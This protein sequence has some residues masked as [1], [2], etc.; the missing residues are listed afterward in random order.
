MNV[1]ELMRQAQRMQAEVQRQLRELVVEGSAG[2]G[3]VVVKLNGLKE[4]LAVRIDRQALEGEE[5]ALVEDLVM[6]AWEE[7]QRRLTQESREVLARLGLP[8]G[9]G[10]LL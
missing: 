6:A 5:P 3:L 4:L 8:P 9:V 1:A 7:A 2:G 10:G